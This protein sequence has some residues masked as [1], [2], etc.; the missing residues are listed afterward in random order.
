MLS[1]SMPEPEIEW[2]A[3]IREGDMEAFRLLVETHQS[4]VINTISKLLGGSDAEAEDLA[5]QVFI[6]VW[7]SASRYQPTAKF[8][9][10][11][12]RITRNLVFN[13]L[14]RRKHL[15]E[16]NEESPELPERAERE[17]D[18]V[19]LEEELQEAI[20]NAIREL[21][22]AQRTAIVLRRY[23]EMPYEEIARVMGTTVPAVKSILFRAR[24]E[25]REKL[26][27]YLE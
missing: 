24:A 6:R 5:Q 16:P 10:W 23:E 8:T 25:L 4:R 7:R 19:L 20:R 14:R 11:L 12:F 9:T 26:A 13:E 2:M 18:R 21:P 1:P 15:G 27:K 3:R 22:E 17:P